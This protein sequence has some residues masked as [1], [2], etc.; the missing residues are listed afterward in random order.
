S[1][2]PGRITREIAVG[3]PRPRSIDNLITPEFTAYKAMI[4]AEMKVAHGTH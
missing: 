4:M 1:A 3:L 2:R